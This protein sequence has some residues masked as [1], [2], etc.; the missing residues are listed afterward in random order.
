MKLF[1]LVAVFVGVFESSPA[2]GTQAV[3]IMARARAVVRPI[4]G[5]K[6][7]RS[8]LEDDDVCVYLADTTFTERESGVVG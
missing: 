6:F 8:I 5:K 3:A 4:K 1:G 7:I 2:A